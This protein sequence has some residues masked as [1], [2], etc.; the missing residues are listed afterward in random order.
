MLAA[1]IVGSMSVFTFLTVHFYAR[2]ALYGAFL[3]KRFFW[4]SFGSIAAIATGRIDGR[5]GVEVDLCDSL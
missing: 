2:W 5:Q 1:K 3:V 4:R